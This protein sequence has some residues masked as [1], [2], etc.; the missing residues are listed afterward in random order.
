MNPA[1]KEYNNM[2]HNRGISK[3]I[4]CNADTVVV[5]AAPHVPYMMMMYGKKPGR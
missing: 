1:A 3:Q 5:P 4:L 2:L